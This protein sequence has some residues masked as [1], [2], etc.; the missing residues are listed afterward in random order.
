[1]LELFAD[2]GSAAVVSTVVGAVVLKKFEKRLAKKKMKSGDTN[3]APKPHRMSNSQK[4]HSQKEKTEFDCAVYSDRLFERKLV[5]EKVIEEHE[6]TVCEDIACPNCKFTRMAKNAEH[7]R[8][9]IERWEEMQK[10]RQ[11]E[12]NESE[13]EKFQHMKKR[14]PSLAGW[15]YADWKREQAANERLRR[16]NAA[17]QNLAHRTTRIAPGGITA[18]EIQAGRSLPETGLYP[19]E[20]CGLWCETKVCPACVAQR[21]RQRDAELVSLLGKQPFVTGRPIDELE[22][23]DRGEALLRDRFDRYA[24]DE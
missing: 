8:E 9:R 11:I 6:M 7:R 20:D 19:C 13:W 5:N 16:L 10:S 17:R 1:M 23:L 12:K 4:K 22:A 14:D 2:P 21:T 15:T 3:K 18:K 24:T